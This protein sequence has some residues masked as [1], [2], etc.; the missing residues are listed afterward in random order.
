MPKPSNPPRVVVVTGASAGA[1]RAIARLFGAKRHRVA[2]VARDVGRLG[3]ARR[4]IE[5]SGG[6]A[7]VCPA[8]TADMAA[9]VRVRDAVLDAWGALDVWVNCAMATV[10]APVW[11]VTADEYRRVTD[12]T[13]LGYVHGTLAAL[14]I[15]R[16]QDRGTIIQVGSA[17]AYRA[18]PLQSAYCAAKFAVRGFTDALRTELLHERSRVR[19]TMV[20]MPGMNTPQFDWAR[21][22]F[23]TKY[24][25][26]G[27]V[28]EPEIAARAVYR[29]VTRPCRELWVGSSTVQAILGEILAPGCMD[30]LMAKRAWDGQ[31][32]RESESPG[33]PDNLETTVDRAVGAHGRFDARAKPRAAAFDPFWGRLAAALLASAALWRATRRRPAMARDT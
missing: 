11:E 4:E 21:N 16:R 6:Q 17:L 33:R 10:V 28:Y 3:A 19:L 15:M 32:T 9:V 31:I 1:G 8:D 5:A 29:A 12:V 26:V 23:S 27:T 2:L 14:E 30:R 18:I 25:P 20:Q 24:Q 13:Y 22:K 7:L